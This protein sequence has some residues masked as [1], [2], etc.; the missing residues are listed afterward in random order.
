MTIAL[1]TLVTAPALVST[2]LGWWSRAAG[3][4]TVARACHE[5]RGPIAA[6]RL[7]LS[8]ASRGDGEL[9]SDR[10][11]AIDLELARAG[12]ALD[13][14]ARSRRPQ[15]PE[16]V[17]LG[18]LLQASV[19][20]LEP[21]AVAHRAALELRRPVAAVPVLGVRLRLAQMSANL[22]ANAIEHGGGAVVVT[23]AADERAVRVEVTDEGPG[24]PASLAELS[25][26]GGRRRTVLR[27]L[28]R[29]GPLLRRE[30]PLLRREGPFGLQRVALRGHGLAIA[31]S[32]VAR[33]GGRL[34]TAPSSA[35]ARLLVELPR[36]AFSGS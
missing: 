22:I 30:G 28:R 2:V 9:T 7:G 21:L 20:A 18:E 6:A 19:A 32:I 12:L 11:R 3:A 24:L 14:L 23:V 10:L 36:A 26:S 5:L 1:W 29:E 31:A 25:G 15:P 16:I 34:S 8:L 4:R 17:D 35:G 27:A 33:H 13:D